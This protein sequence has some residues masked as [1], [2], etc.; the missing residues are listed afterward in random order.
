[1][2]RDSADD[3]SETRFGIRADDIADQNAAQSTH[4]HAGRPAH[5]AAQAQEDGRGSNIAHRDVGDGDVFEQAAVDGFERESLTAFEDA[6]RN[7]DVLETSVRL[8]AELNAAVRVVLLAR[9]ESLER[10]IEE[11]AK[12]VDPGYV[13]IRD[14]HIFRGARVSE[15]ERTLGTDGIVPRRIHRAVRD[16]DVAAAVDIDAVAVGVTFEIVDREVV[17]AGREDAEVSALEDRKVAQDYV[18]AILQADGLIRNARVFGNRARAVAMTESAAPDEAGTDDRDI[19]EAL[20]PE[21]TVS[22]MVVTVVLISVPSSVGLRQVVTA[23]SRRNRISRDDDR[24]LIQRDRDVALEV[25]G[26]AQIIPGGKVDR[27]SSGCVGGFDRAIDRWRVDGLAVAGCAE[28]LHVEDA[29]RR[30][31][32]LRRGAK[33]QCGARQACA[34][35]AQEVAARIV[36]SRHGACPGTDPRFARTDSRGRLSPHEQNKSSVPCRHASVLL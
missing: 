25:N 32:R 33:W 17:A 28:E 35:D 34:A 30:G 31:S 6:V 4:R 10:A 14:R 8:G 18:A 11:R 21:Q 20:A 22:P 9:I 23:R 3:R 2:S 13:A 36:I 7:C 15:G 12:F 5:A 1:M 24:V 26:I 27:T 29:G 19:L 16:A